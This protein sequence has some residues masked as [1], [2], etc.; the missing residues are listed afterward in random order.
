MENTQYQNQEDLTSEVARVEEI[1]ES[2]FAKA[3]SFAAVATKAESADETKNSGDGLEK[4]SFEFNQQSPQSLMNL[5]SFLKNE[6]I[7]L[8]NLMVDLESKKQKVERQVQINKDALEKLSLVEKQAQEVINESIKV[9]KEN[10]AI[11]QQTVKEKTVNDDV[12]EPLTLQN[13][14][15]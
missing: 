11:F 12:D 2:A 7:K 5:G 6:I 14:W 10:E 13:I 3:A 8:Q 9:Q 15:R 1:E 4:V